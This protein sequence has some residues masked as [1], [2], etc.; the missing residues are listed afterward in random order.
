[1]AIAS[2]E[3]V[4]NKVIPILNDWFDNAEEHDK[5]KFVMLMFQIVTSRGPLS[6]KFLIAK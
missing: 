3:E 2:G 5:Q 1:M 6:S 4:T